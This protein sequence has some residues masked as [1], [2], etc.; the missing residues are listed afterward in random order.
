MKK[1]YAQVPDELIG[2]YT[3]ADIVFQLSGSAD[4]TDMTEKYIMHIKK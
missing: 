1:K 4:G 2:E 3:D